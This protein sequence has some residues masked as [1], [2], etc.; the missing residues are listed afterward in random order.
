[1]F[2]GIISYI[3]LLLSHLISHLTFGYIVVFEANFE[4]MAQSAAPKGH[5]KKF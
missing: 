2:Y 4:A 5:R 3:Y 1:M